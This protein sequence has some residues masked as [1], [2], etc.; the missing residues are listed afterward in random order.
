MGTKSAL[1]SQLGQD[2]WRCARL[3][4]EVTVEASK[5]IMTILGR[6]AR[7]CKVGALQEAPLLASLDPSRR[8]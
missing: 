2:C 6:I 7:Y 5:L 4:A 3:S 1:S 8:S